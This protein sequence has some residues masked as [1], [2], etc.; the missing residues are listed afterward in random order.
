LTKRHDL[1]LLLS[2]DLSAVLRDVQNGLELLD[3]VEDETHAQSLTD[4]RQHF[5]RAYEALRGKPRQASPG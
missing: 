1:A 2:N 5:E 3:H 4:A